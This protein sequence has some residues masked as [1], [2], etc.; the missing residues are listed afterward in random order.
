MAPTVSERNALIAATM[1]VATLFDRLPTPPVAIQVDGRNEFMKALEAARETS[2]Y[3]P[4]CTTKTERGC[5]THK[6]LPEKRS[7]IWRY[8]IIFTTTYAS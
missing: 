4:I 3:P 6:S 8:R 1:V 2:M 5:R 7:T